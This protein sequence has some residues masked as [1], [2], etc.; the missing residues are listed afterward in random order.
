MKIISWNVNGIRACLNK[1][2]EEF[3]NENDPDIVCIQETKANKDQVE[4]DIPGYKQYWNSAERKGYSGTLILSKKE[5]NKHFVAVSTNSQKVI[6][7]GID[8]QNMFKFW[9]WVGGRYSL[10]SAIGL[11][12]VCAIGYDH[13]IDLLKGAERMD[14]HFLNAPLESNAPT[15]MAFIGIWYNNFFKTQTQVILP[16]DQRLAYFS[17]Y[18]QQADME[19][20][21]K[22]IDRNGNQV[23]YET[24]QIIWGEPGTNG[25]HAFYQLL[26][27]GTK[28][29]PCDFIAAAVPAHD[30]TDHHDKLMANFIAQTEALMKGKNIKSCLIYTSPSPRD[31]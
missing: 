9:D 30:K 10:W 31:S 26:H 2:F 19:S 27:Q 24:G 16:Y 18:L 22:S 8:P 14:E 29:V 7:F 1:G 5:I 12:I 11:S 25:Q 13:F 28:I 15:L 3:I 20:N 21:G 17:K 4:L 6:E 23:K